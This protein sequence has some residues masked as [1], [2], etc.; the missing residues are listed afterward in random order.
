MNNNK[1]KALLLLLL[2]FIEAKSLT[3][4]AKLVDYICF[5]IRNNRINKYK[6]IKTFSYILLLKLSFII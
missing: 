3:Y 4:S 1:I 6:S 2:T 5:S